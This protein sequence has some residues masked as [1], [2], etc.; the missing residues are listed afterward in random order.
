MQHLGL[1][2]GDVCET[3]YLLGEAVLGRGAG[4]LSGRGIVRPST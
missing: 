4:H 2:A 3:P 1:W